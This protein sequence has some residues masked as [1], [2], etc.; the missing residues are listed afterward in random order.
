MK[1][2]KYLKNSQWDKVI[3]YSGL[4]ELEKLNKNDRR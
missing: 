4:E 1:K 3:C 2:D